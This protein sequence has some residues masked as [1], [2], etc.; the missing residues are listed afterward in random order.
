MARLQKQKAKDKLRKQFGT[1]TKSDNI[2]SSFYSPSKENQP[3]A[4]NTPT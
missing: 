2:Q 1:P 4:R 3:L